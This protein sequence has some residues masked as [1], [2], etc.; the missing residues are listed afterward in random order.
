M[1]TKVLLCLAIGLLLAGGLFASQGSAAFAQTGAQAVGDLDPTFADGGMAFVGDLDGPAELLLQPDGKILAVTTLH[2]TTD[3]IVVLRFN[4]DGGLDTGFGDAGQVTVGGSDLNEQAY[5]LLLQRD[6]KIVVL[7]S[8]IRRTP[9]QIGTSITR[10][11]PDGSIDTGFGDYGT[12]LIEEANAKALVQLPDD[13]LMAVG[14]ILLLENETWVHC[15]NPNGADVGIILARIDTA[16]AWDRSFGCDGLAMDLMGDALGQDG[17]HVTSAEVQ[18]DGKI[19]ISG[20]EED[21]DWSQWGVWRYNSDG[22]RDAEGFGGGEACIDCGAGAS[23]VALQPDG[24]VVI[25]FTEDPSELESFHYFGVAR[26]NLDLSRDT[27][28]GE[29][30]VVHTIFGAPSYDDAR[31]VAVQPD[32]KIIVVGR[33][34][35]ND[36]AVVVR[37]LPDG[38]L[39]MGFGAGGI[40][41]LDLDEGGSANQTAVQPDGK[42]LVGGNRGSRLFLARLLVEGETPGSAEPPS[43]D[44]IL[45][46]AQPDEPAQVGR[47]TPLALRLYSPEGTLLTTEQP[48]SVLVYGPADGGGRGPLLTTIQPG[49]RK[50]DL[51]FIQRGAIYKAIFSSRPYD[52]PQNAMLTAVVQAASGEELGSVMFVVRAKS[53]P[54]RMR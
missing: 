42:I 11:N 46:R 43:V 15:I 54:A 41:L 2:G 50:N 45:P 6:G 25:S 9:L 35:E 32:G 16:G 22:S 31:D 47:N 37:Y 34:Y 18:P 13:S 14:T 28:F 52:L 30:G 1:K 3:D 21:R 36:D 33:S 29:N 38:R 40:K 7:G 20:S 39:D 8:S 23:S 12:I 5:D 19:V 24:K 26:L 17:F 48:L 27:G 44:W 51:R 4:P 10:L 53:R 49:R